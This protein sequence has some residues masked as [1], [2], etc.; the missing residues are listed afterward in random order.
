MRTDERRGSKITRLTMMMMMMTYLD[1]NQSRST[2]EVFPAVGHVC[3]LAFSLGL[4]P[5]R[6][7]KRINFNRS[8][9]KPKPKQMHGSN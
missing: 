2:E 5:P 8:V 1:R 7:E 3:P 6:K 9:F 4:L